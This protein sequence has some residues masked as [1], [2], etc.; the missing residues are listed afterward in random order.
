MTAAWEVW[1][2]QGAAR[3]PL[4]GDVPGIVRVPLHGL[5][6]PVA[7]ASLRTTTA[8]TRRP[9]P[10]GMQLPRAPAL[11]VPRGEAWG[12][13]ALRRPCPGALAQGRPLAAC[14]QGAHAARAPQ[15]LQGAG[16]R[17]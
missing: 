16:P 12:V 8:L 5:L 13:L 1:A 9:P 6:A 15:S 7:R 4:Y 2:L 11:L 3:G 17:R 14:Q 10:S